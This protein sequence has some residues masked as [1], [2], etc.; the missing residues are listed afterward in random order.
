M[1]RKPTKDFFICPLCGNRDE[2]PFYDNPR[3]EPGPGRVIPTGR[4]LKK[5]KEFFCH[6]CGHTGWTTSAKLR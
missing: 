5:K 1:A 3:F 2:S 4:T 6:D